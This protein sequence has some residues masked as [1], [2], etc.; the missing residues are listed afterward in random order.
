MPITIS[1]TRC[2]MCPHDMNDEFCD[3]NTQGVFV[4]IWAR[5]HWQYS[6]AS[7]NKKRDK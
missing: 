4:D 5:S 2:L 1:F 7:Q 3:A 6:V